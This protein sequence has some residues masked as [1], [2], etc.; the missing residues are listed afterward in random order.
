MAG[1]K[2]IRDV[3][4]PF[5]RLIFSVNLRGQTVWV[6]DGVEL[7]PDFKRIGLFIPSYSISEDVSIDCTFSGDMYLGEMEDEKFKTPILFDM[8]EISFPVFQNVGKIA[9]F[10]KSIENYTIIARSTKPHKLAKDCKEILAKNFLQDIKIEHV[11]KQLKT[12][13]ALL[14]QYFKKDFGMTPAQYR[15]ALRVEYGIFLL[16]KGVP[17]IEASLMCGYND[18]S[19][20]YKQFKDVFYQSPGSL[21][22]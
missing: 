21:K 4:G 16:A 15:R 8:G 3:T 18:L 22:R 5:F 20:F 14:S 7:N 9:D 6:S 17:V 2:A 1:R 13:N 11:A 10:L 19:R 12:S